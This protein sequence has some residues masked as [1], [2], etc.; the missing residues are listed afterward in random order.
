MKEPPR[1]TRKPPSVQL[2]DAKPARF[3]F[4]FDKDGHD[5]MKGFFDFADWKESCIQQGLLLK[6]ISDFIAKEEPN[7]EQDEEVHVEISSLFWSVKLIPFL[8]KLQSRIQNDFKLQAQLTPTIE[9]PSAAI[10]TRRLC[11]PHNFSASTIYFGNFSNRG[12]LFVHWEISTRKM[13]QPSD[14]S[15]LSEHLNP[16]TAEFI[17][18]EMN[19]YFK[20]NNFEFEKFDDNFIADITYTLRLPY[21]NVKRMYVDF[22]AKQPGRGESPN[23][24]YMLHFHTAY[25]V[26][27]FRLTAK[28]K[29]RPSGGPQ[30]G[31]GDRCRSIFRGRD[32][33]DH[34]LRRNGDNDCI[35]DSPVFSVA[36]SARS[37]TDKQMYTLL[38]R[39]HHIG[40]I[41]IYVTPIQLVL[42]ILKPGPNLRDLEAIDYVKHDR[43]NYIQI[44]KQDAKDDQDDLFTL[45]YLV[46]AVLSRGAPAKKVIHALEDL[47]DSIEN[48]HVN[49]SIHD[50][51]YYLLNHPAERQEL[52]GAAQK[53]RIYESAKGCVQM[54]NRVIREYGGQNSNNLLRVVFRED[55]GGLLRN[56]VKHDFIIR[57]AGALLSLGLDIGG[58]HFS[59]LGQ[60]NSQLRDQGSYFIRGDI[61]YA[62]EIRAALGK[63]NKLKTVPKIV[64]R[65][66]QCFTQ[67]RE[68]GV[69]LVR[70]DYRTECDVRG[71]SSTTEIKDKTGGPSTRK[72]E[73]YTFS[74]GVGRISQK[75]FREVATLC[76]HRY[77]DYTPSVVQFR[78]RGFK[79]VLTMDPTLDHYAVFLD[80]LNLNQQEVNFY[81]K[82]LCSAIHNT[83]KL[84]LLLN[85]GPSGVALNRP[86]INI[87]CQVAEAQG[88][89]VHQRVQERIRLLLEKHAFR[90]AKV[91]CDEKIARDKLKEL[92]NRLNVDYLTVISGMHLT[93][94]PFFR[95]LL[96]TAVHY[97][98][99]RTLGKEQIEIPHNL[100][101]SMFGVI[102]ESGLLQYGQVFIQYTK[103]IN[104]RISLHKAATEI[105]EGPVLITKNPA[106]VG[107]D[108]RMFTAVNIP[109]LRHL[110]DVVVFPQYGPRPHPDEMAGSDLDGDEYSVIWDPE[111]FFEHN[112][113]A[114]NFVKHEAREIKDIL[115]EEFRNE[116]IE[117]IIEYMK[118][119]MIGMV[120][121]A[122]LVQSD[123]Y[124]IFEEI[125]EKLAEQ[126]SI[127]VDFAKTG[128][129]P[130]RLEPKWTKK[131][132]TGEDGELVEYS[133]PGTKYTR[134]P[135][136]MHRDYDPVYRCRRTVGIVY[137]GI[138]EVQ[139]LLKGSVEDDS[140]I[141]IELDPTFE[142]PGWET[143]IKEAQEHFEEWVHS[144]K[145]ILER[146]GV[147]TAAELLTGCILE[148]RNKAMEK[149][150]DQVT[151]FTTGQTIETTMTNLWITFRK[152]FFE[153]SKEGHCY[154]DDYN[155]VTEAYQE[156][157]VNEHYPLNRYVVSNSSTDPKVK[158]MKQKAVAYYRIAY[159]RASKERGD[160]SIFTAFPWLVWDVLN[161]LKKDRVHDSKKIEAVYEETH[162]KEFHVR[163]CEFI[164]DYCQ[165]NEQV[166]QEVKE[167]LDSIVDLRKILFDS[168]ENRKYVLPECI[169]EANDKLTDFWTLCCF[170]AE[171]IN[172]SEIQ[173]IRDLHVVIL[174]IRFANGELLTSKTQKFRQSNDEMLVEDA[175]QLVLDFLEYLAG[176]AF[177]L[178]PMTS[179]EEYG[180]DSYL[181]GVEWQNVHKAARRTLYTISFSGHFDTLIGVAENENKEVSA[182]ASLHIHEDAPF[183][184]EFEDSTD[185]NLATVRDELI[186]A[187]GLVDLQLRRAYRGAPKQSGRVRVTAM[188]SADSIRRLRRLLIIDSI[189]NWEYFGEDLEK[190]YAKRV[191]QRVK[192]LNKPGG[193]ALE[194]EEDL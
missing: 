101:R 127:A 145:R 173:G 166:I 103:T 86:F 108:V 142:Y 182:N 9:L 61:N 7:G 126:H 4:L 55:A 133:I 92:P 30:Y 187:L 132:T 162:A 81:Q 148:M 176:R 19:A 84:I 125:S 94:E 130:D 163:L 158:K 70:T 90:C 113:K 181:T 75:Y 137:R 2:G 53:R 34:P 119:D 77:R 21:K 112:Q 168:L 177:L 155:S 56:L 106:I 60:S 104:A 141:A 120:S 26:E 73:P 45:R 28:Q 170:I 15:K 59:H 82:T 109:E 10:F 68:S 159:E 157:W 143:M 43:D 85:I 58:V 29:E 23:P 79:G 136:F 11:K 179:F 17:H 192:L 160:R 96:K 83:S 164:T 8:K 194:E 175:G 167:K 71:G 152:N 185:V 54:G 36:F 169:R 95:S 91:L 161:L 66:G 38:S 76:D 186:S 37:W 171:W 63:F 69:N 80:K 184:T 16:I 111:L 93:S 156:V 14:I 134:C 41:T 1:S 51:F 22:D 72:E 25:P 57:R 140:E 114:M 191:T 121:T 50:A 6:K 13:D 67:S 46:E 165:R 24:V 144:V 32:Y 35:A 98:L 100:G 31:E 129:P 20:F 12:K 150:G 87:L 180:L 149:E 183:I 74:D 65:M 107:G 122:H 116:M 174:F 42:K 146:Y 105:R 78:F 178:D 102:D 99:R 49:R 64:A 44:L 48:L 193:L 5:Q 88:K 123:H 154:I 147:A 151:Y 139:E 33:D 131:K 115:P 189:D 47:V 27:I 18:D 190:E 117:F 3:H 128:V 118:N 52:T 39:L 153:S 40:G 172:K 89:H 124:G 62:N 188:G 135:D 97:S 110:V 138:K